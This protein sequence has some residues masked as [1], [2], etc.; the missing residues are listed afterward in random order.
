M[1]KEIKEGLIRACDIIDLIIEILRGS[2]NLAEAKACL[3]TGDTGNITFKTQKSKKAASKLSFTE[4]QA[5]AILEMR[6]YRLIGL[7]ILA[8]QKEYEEIL[9]RIQEYEEILNNPEAMKKVIKKTCRRSKRSTVLRERPLWK[10]RRRRWS[11]RR[12]WK[13]GRLSL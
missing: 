11:S 4:R 9:K 3:M 1:Q 7:E 8:L 5:T 6:L 2:K 10:M 13:S 12:K